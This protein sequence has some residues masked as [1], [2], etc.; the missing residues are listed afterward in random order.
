ILVSGQPI[1][2]EEAWRIGLVHAVS[3]DPEQ[4]ALDWFDRGLKALSP[5]SLRIAMRAARFDFV[6]RVT[7]KLAAV[8]RLYLGELMSSHDAVE[9]LNAFL[10]KRPAKWEAR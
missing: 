10:E 3:D 2:A 5:S 4:A 8:E 9:G 1:G 6:E 7:A